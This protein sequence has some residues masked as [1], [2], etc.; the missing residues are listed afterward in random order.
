MN[1]KVIK[2]IKIF[3]CCR[4]LYNDCKGSQLNDNNIRVLNEGGMSNYISHFFEGLD[5]S[6]IKSIEIDDIF[7]YRNLNDISY[8][9][10]GGCY[11]SEE[12]V[13][14]TF[15][16]YKVDY[17][18]KEYVLGREDDDMWRTADL[19]DNFRN[20]LQKINSYIGSSRKASIC[21]VHMV[22]G[23]L[24]L[25]EYHPADRCINYTYGNDKGLDSLLE[26]VIDTSTRFAFRV[27]DIYWF[28][29]GT[30]TKISARRRDDEEYT[31]VI[32]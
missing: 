1:Y 6:M 21:E 28:V 17:P 19:S 30:Y 8:L 32:S 23:D 31:L 14:Q 26:E 2:N 22:G 27:K 20:L 13:L 29:E 4:K 10:S 15:S 12:G 24:L 7:K 9:Y 18:K 25:S 3:N 5:I 16:P 11:L